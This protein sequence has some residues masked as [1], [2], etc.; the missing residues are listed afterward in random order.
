MATA[1]RT[2]PPITRVV[3]AASSPAGAAYR[4]AR[5]QGFPARPGLDL[6]DFGGK[7]I[8]NLT[9][10]HVYLGG[11]AAWST[12]DITKIDAGLSAAMEDPHLNNV[13]A[14]YYPDGKPTSAF[15]RSRVLSAAARVPRY[16]RRVRRDAGPVER[17]VRLR[18]VVH[19]VLLHAAARNRPR[20]RNELRSRT[21][22]PRGGGGERRAA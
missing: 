15:T 9:F 1:T 22:R 11:K 10:T 12:D 2:I 14:Q 16:G 3:V 18:P 8:E 4:E 6:H 19:R 20:R 7:T 21:C 5:V 17:A 13:L